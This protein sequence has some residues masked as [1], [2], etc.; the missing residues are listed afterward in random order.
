MRR[1]GVVLFVVAVGLAS[2]L[3][4]PRAQGPAGDSNAPG[5]TS[6][7][8]PASAS[9]PATGPIV[10]LKWDDLSGKTA[11]HVRAAELAVKEGVKVN[12]GVFG[13]SLEDPSPEYVAWLK[14]LRKSGQF[15]FW[16][17]G[18][19]GFGNV[20]PNT[21]KEIKPEDIARGQE[22]SKK[23]LGEPFI[24]YGIH[25]VQMDDARWKALADSPEIKAVF[26]ASAPPGW[27]GK[28]FCIDKRA[29]FEDVSL[30]PSKQRLADSFQ[31]VI[32]N[33]D[34][35]YV[36]GHPNA[37]KTEQDWDE[38][39]AALVYLKEQNCRFMTVSE[40]L[41]SR[42]R[43]AAKGASTQ[44]AAPAAAPRATPKAD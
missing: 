2:A 24:A 8:A 10:L 11:S 25:A 13:K 37:W 4:A 35:V 3:C 27:Q 38:V 1:I 29:A 33:S 44:T 42:S 16:N 12:F 6:A 39:K 36:Q 17:H 14:D 20:D 32:K 23:H 7:S 15:E 21:K 40:F 9:R 5:G 34:Y 31:K 30:K 22:L 28:A 41:K 18:F 26:S 19:H 43:A